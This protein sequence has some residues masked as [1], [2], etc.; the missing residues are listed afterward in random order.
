MTVVAYVAGDGGAKQTLAALSQVLPGVT[1]APPASNGG[2]LLVA[3]RKNDVRLLI[4]GTSDS[5]AGR[6]LENRAHIAAAHHDIPVVQ[7]EDYP[8][9]FRPGRH[10]RCNLL[11]AD[12]DFSLELARKRWGKRTPPAIAVTTPRYDEL[13]SMSKAKSTAP[14]QDGLLWVGQ[15]E[16]R[17]CLRTLGRVLP[18]IKTFGLELW[19][20]AHPRDAGYRLGAY[21]KILNGH[22]PALRDVTD[23][24]WDECIRL[25]PR[26]LLTQYSSLAIDAGFFGIPSVHLL[27]PDAGGGRLLKKKGYSI[28][29]LCLS[30]A[31]F[32]IT[33]KDSEITVLRSAIFDTTARRMARNAFNAYFP[34][35]VSSASI[36]ARHLYNLGLIDRSE[37]HRSG[38]TVA[39]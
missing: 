9:N 27:Y 20:R 8:G 29:P 7:V 23:L 31:A 19:F 13:R 26:L 10:R 14:Q 6:A 28:P 17:D 35:G 34:N 3:L 4:V 15:P 37:K 1:I 22:V 33:E 18:V 12:G 39:S 30:G 38:P 16:T 5:A 32:A 24:A 21:R 25:A 2:D 36:I 11:V